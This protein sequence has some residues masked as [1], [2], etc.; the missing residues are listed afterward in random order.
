MKTVQ[1]PSPLFITVNP[2]PET[3][4]ISIGNNELPLHYKEGG[5]LIT[6]SCICDL[7]G[8]SDDGYCDLYTFL[9]YDYLWSQFHSVINCPPVLINVFT[10]DHLIY[11]YHYGSNTNQFYTLLKS[12]IVNQLTPEDKR[13][14]LMKLISLY[15][16][17]Y[18]ASGFTGELNEMSTSLGVS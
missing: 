16:N 5:V 8:I 2:N 3:L 14:L 6:L 10:N 11:V 4:K 18:E 17:I 12:Y 1:I 15:D 9:E 7:L 13:P